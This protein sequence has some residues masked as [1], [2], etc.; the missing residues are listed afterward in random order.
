MDPVELERREA[1]GEAAV[2]KRIERATQPLLD[3]IDKL[4][5]ENK[6]LWTALSRISPDCEHLSHKRKDY[7]SLSDPCPVEILIRTILKEK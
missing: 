6:D 3:K 5:S 2:Q 1:R 4:Q 7:H